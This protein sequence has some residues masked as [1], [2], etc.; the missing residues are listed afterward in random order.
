M[1]VRKR[2]FEKDLEKLISKHK[3]HLY[4]GGE[5]VSFANLEIRNANFSDTN[6]SGADF[7]NS[8]FVNANFSGSDLTDANFSGTNLYRANLSGCI[9]EYTNFKNARLSH[10]ILESVNAFKASFHETELDYS[11]IYNVD[12]SGCDLNRANLSHANIHCGYELP[13]MICPQGEIKGYVKALNIPKIPSYADDLTNNYVI[14]ELLIPA[15]AKRSNGTTRVCRADKMKVVSITK[16][17]GSDAGYDAYG[18]NRVYRIG[19]EY[20]TSSFDDNRW[21]RDDKAYHFFLTREEAEQR[22]IE[23]ND[24]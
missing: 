3:K 2:I 24:Y 10:A 16:M 6:L 22:W 21:N 8:A 5:K 14:V 23:F 7:S 4:Q 12:F 15:D 9:C 11:L 13:E 19:Q 17:D 18:H 20:V 1:P